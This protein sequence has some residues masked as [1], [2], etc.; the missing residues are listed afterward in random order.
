MNASLTRKI[1]Y[2]FAGLN[3]LIIVAWWLHVSGLTAT[4]TPTRLVAIGR[5][6]GLIAAYAALIELFLMSRLP[7]VERSFGLTRLVKLHTWNGYVMVYALL[8]HLAFLIY[9]YQPTLMAN[10]IPQF[11]DFLFNYPDMIKATIGSA[12]IFL[13]AAIS[14]SIARK[15]VGY[16]IWYLIHLT[17]YIAIILAFFHQLTTGGDFID[18]P[19][20]RY[21]WVGLIIAAFALIFIYRIASPYIV[22]LVSKPKV[23]RVVPESKDVYSVYISGDKF[24]LLRIKAGQYFGFQFLGS[25][26]WAQSHPFTISQAAKDNE[27]RITFKIYGGYTA[28]LS[29]IKPGSPVLLDGPRGN[30]TWERSRLKQTLMIA[31]GI[32][33]TPMRALIEA[34]PHGQDITVLYACN[35]RDEAPLLGEFA[36]LNTAAKLKV[37][38]VFSNE[39]GRITPELIAKMVPDFAKREVYICGPDPMVVGLTKFLLSADLSSDDIH[40]ERFAY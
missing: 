21:Y 35:N 26:V 11:L 2:G 39:L 24:N 18:Y 36:N 3:A 10:P 6:T 20:F 34:A 13:V 40:T 7:V 1:I 25:G 16:E 37:I 17:T 12:M 5:I 9:G 29:K 33:I 38:P 30:S 15:R 28:N 23:D 27:L 14:I 22:W 8:A 19:L 31:G 32:G 4:N